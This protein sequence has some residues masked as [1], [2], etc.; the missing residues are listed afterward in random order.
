MNLKRNNTRIKISTLYDLLVSLD[1]NRLTPITS[2]YGLQTYVCGHV[3]MSW[4]RVCV[5]FVDGRGNQVTYI[6]LG[7]DH[8]DKKKGKVYEEEDSE[9][10]LCPVIGKASG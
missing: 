4:V 5:E 2:L 9:V 7:V 10:L 3:C 8:K 6:V 1:V